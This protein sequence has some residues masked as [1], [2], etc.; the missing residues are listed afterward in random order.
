[1][2]VVRI[3]NE[4]YSSIGD[5]N[6][7]IDYVTNPEETR[8]KEDEK[9]RFIGGLGVNPYHSEMMIQQMLAVKKIF[10]KEEGRQLRHIIVSFEKEWNVDPQTALYIAYGIAQYY[11]NRYQ[12]CFGVHQS[13]DNLHIHFVMNTVSFIDGRMYSG[14]FR[15]LEQFKTH[16]SEVINR[17]Y[18]Q[19]GGGKRSF[20][21]VPVNQ[22][23][24]PANMEMNTPKC[25]PA[26]YFY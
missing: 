5:L 16:V 6:R 21:E 26:I 9:K 19:Y 23:V 20:N 12:I 18:P 7:V 2:E 3:V 25:R 17:Y 8:E 4:P 13:T 15:E 10:H 1:M 24:K 22:M 14:A 11:S